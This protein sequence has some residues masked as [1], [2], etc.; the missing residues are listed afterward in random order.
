[1][2]IAV[3]GKIDRFSLQAKDYAKFRPKYPE[4]LFRTLIAFDNESD[5]KPEGHVYAKTALDVATGT[6]FMAKQL[7]GRYAKG[8]L[9]SIKD[10]RYISSMPPP[11]Q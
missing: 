10:Q 1:M 8:S 6:G 11:F 3:D 9:N 2:D 5:F 4:E 7:S